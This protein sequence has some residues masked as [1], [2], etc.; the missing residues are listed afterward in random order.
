MLFHDDAASIYLW[1]FD[2]LQVWKVAYD[3]VFIY[4]QLNHV[5]LLILIVIFL[6]RRSVRN[7]WNVQF[8]KN[9]LLFTIISNKNKSKISTILFRHK[10][11]PRHQRNDIGCR[12]PTRCYYSCSGLCMHFHSRRNFGYVTWETL[13]LLHFFRFNYRSSEQRMIKLIN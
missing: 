3:L 11:L 1:Y 12:L 7:L 6:L 2:S 10:T 9:L 8:M 5:A 4:N 13:H